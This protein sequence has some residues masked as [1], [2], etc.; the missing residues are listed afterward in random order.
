MARIH[1]AMVAITREVDAIG[2]DSRNQQ[3]GFAFRGIDAV[4]NHLHPL[5][6]KHGVIILPKVLE[7]RT[8][9]RQTKSGG[10]LIYR[11]I[12]TEFSFVAED[13]STITSTILSEGMDSGDKAVN[14]A[15]AVGLKYALTQ[16]LLLPYDEVDPDSESHPDNWRKPAQEPQ[17]APEVV[18]PTATGGKTATKP[19]GKG[20]VAPPPV[21]I[22]PRGNTAAQPPLEEPPQ[23]PAV[24]TSKMN[25]PKPVAKSDK[26]VG[27]NG[28]PQR[29]PYGIPN[30][31][32][33]RINAETK[34]RIVAAFGKHNIAE[35]FLMTHSGF[36]VDSWTEDMKIYALA[37]YKSLE[38]GMQAEE[39]FAP[40]N[41]AK[42]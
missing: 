10:N 41:D 26:I 39:V 20:K 17:K 27:M 9:D 35:Q 6:A 32:S 16:M 21:I 24:D 36:P 14:K 12:K 28:K 29:A 11:I 22:D 42:K 3:Q 13:G 25:P 4:M 15:L 38:N 34:A 2:K 37:D 5:F 30:S 18:K 1:E 33:P 8:E 7:D 23:V 19:A 31:G 40:E